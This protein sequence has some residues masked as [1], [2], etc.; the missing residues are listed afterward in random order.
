MDSLRQHLVRRRGD[1]NTAPSNLRIPANHVVIRP[2]LVE[3]AVHKIDYQGDIDLSELRFVALEDSESYNIDS[4][5]DIV[6][7]QVPAHCNSHT[8]DL[9]EYG[10]GILDRYNGSDYL[11]LCD[12]N[13]R[14]QLDHDKFRGHHVELSVPRKGPMPLD[15]VM[16]DASYIL[17]SQ[18]DQ[19]YNV[20]VANCNKEGRE[21]AV[22]GQVIFESFGKTLYAQDDVSGMHLLMMG[23]AICLFFTICTFRIHMGTR[24][25]YTHSTLIPIFHDAGGII[26]EEEHVLEN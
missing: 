11:R 8:C 19:T 17:A 3:E 12:L 4:F 21:I 14:L 7:Y 6:V 25:D 20:M 2:G 16:E 5:V 9:S 23:I 15:R 18:R 13:G 1:R 24:A 26:V 10:V 22:T